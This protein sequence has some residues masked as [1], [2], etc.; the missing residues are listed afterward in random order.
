MDKTHSQKSFV[1]KMKG[2]R[3]YENEVMENKDFNSV[4]NSFV[5][6]MRKRYRFLRWR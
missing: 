1:L 6:G 2:V 4:G 3:S 5:A